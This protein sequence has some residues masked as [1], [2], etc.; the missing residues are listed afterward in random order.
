M[1]EVRRWYSFWN[2][3]PAIA[4][5]AAAQ[6]FSIPWWRNLVTISKCAS[7]AEAFYSVQQTQAHGWSRAVV[8]HQIESGWDMKSESN[9]ESS[10]LLTEV[11]HVPSH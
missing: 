3:G 2:Q 11:N 9:I 5:Q 1:N 8:T 7:H 4:K 10:F 6:L